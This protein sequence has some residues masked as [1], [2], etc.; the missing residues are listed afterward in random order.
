L[1]DL[2]ARY[3]AQSGSA[4]GDLSG[5]YPNP[6]VAKLNG[7]AAS[8][9]AQITQAL[10]TRNGQLALRDFISVM[11]YGATGNGSTDDTT[12][13]QNAINHTPLGATL[14]FPTGQYII[15]S[16]LVFAQ[17][18]TVRGSAA[19]MWAG[20]TAYG[21]NWNFPQNA[22]FFSGSVVYMTTAATDAI[23]ITVQQESVNF[24]DF[25]VVFGPPAGGGSVLLQNTGHGFNC[26][27]PLNGANYQLGMFGAHW[28]NV[29]VLGHDGS[30]YGY[31][32]LNT[33]LCTFTH[34][35]AFG[36][37]GIKLD[38]NFTGA[39]G[40]GAGSGNNTFVHPYLVMIAGTVADVINIGATHTTEVNSF[41]SPQCWVTPG[42]CGGITPTTPSNSQKFWNE[43][44]GRNNNFDSADLE[45]AGTNTIYGGVTTGGGYHVLPTGTA[46]ARPGGRIATS[47]GVG[48]S[49]SS[50]NWSLEL[51]NHLIT[52]IGSQN[53]A[54]AAG[55]SAGSGPPTPLIAGFTTGTCSFGTGT[56]P[57]TGAQVVITAAHGYPYTSNG[58]LTA[59]VTPQ[60]AATQALG[61]Y[62][63][64][65]TLTTVTLAAANAPSA[66][67]A[68]TTYSFSFLLTLALPA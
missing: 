11:D 66:S 6:G 47:Y 13:I 59:L 57:S 67:Q 3:V 64:A 39:V 58:T 38:S 21:S 62:V 43:V 48:S 49:G 46:M 30:H 7:V 42:A 34:I 17:A 9:Y 14:W 16:P 60:N 36:G 68:N 22:P 53:A 44:N 12:A 25:A 26:I 5:T 50:T 61:L 63:S 32:L 35:F 10:V 37:G 20:S 27:P 1:S 45:T 31:D 40:A 18:I 4:G 65:T 2:D 23:H 29:Y 52:G 55:S 41:Y 15:S 19:S 24:K 28:E 8:G 33:G 54:A 56:G 51:I